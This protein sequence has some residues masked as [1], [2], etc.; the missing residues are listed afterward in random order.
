MKSNVP[1]PI[2]V[3]ADSGKVL[4]FPGVTRELQQSL[5]HFTGDYL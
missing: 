3:P 4:K 5:I 2:V 1:Q